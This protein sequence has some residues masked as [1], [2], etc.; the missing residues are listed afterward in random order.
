MSSFMEVFFYCGWNGG[1]WKNWFKFDS[2]L[3]KN[4]NL[5]PLPTPIFSY[6]LFLIKNNLRRSSTQTA[7]SCISMN[8]QINWREEENRKNPIFFHWPRK[9]WLFQKVSFHIYLGLEF[10]NVVTD[11][12]VIKVFL[13]K[14]FIWFLME[15]IACKR[16]IV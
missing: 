2:S 16:D 8:N 7:L 4:F 12:R 15:I 13:K 1:R 14:I 3:T 11:L 6:F 5:H 9:S 10:V